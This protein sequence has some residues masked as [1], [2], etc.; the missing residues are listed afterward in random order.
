LKREEGREKKIEGKLE[1]RCRWQRKEKVIVKTIAPRPQDLVSFVDHR[2][3][4]G[5]N[6]GGVE[7]AGEMGIVARGK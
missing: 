6:E 1:R 2:K 4:R 3:D 5:A 7:T